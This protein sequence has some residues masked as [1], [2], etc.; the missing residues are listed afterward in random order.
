MLLTSKQPWEDHM[1]VGAQTLVL[2]RKEQ[3]H[4]VTIR[5]WAKKL[6]LT[7]AQQ[8]LNRKWWIV[9]AIGYIFKNLFRIS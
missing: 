3:A 5:A 7:Q 2:A 1:I 8:Y 6:T 9:R 4:Q